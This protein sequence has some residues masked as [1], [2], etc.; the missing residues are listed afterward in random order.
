MPPHA[1]GS[2]DIITS[3]HAM[4]REIGFFIVPEFEILD[5][6]GPLSAF[7]MVEMTDGTRPYRLRVVSEA[8]GAVVSTAWLEITTEKL[9]ALRFDTLIVV[10]GRGARLD[11]QPET[12]LDA[13]RSAT[14]RTRRIASVCTGAF[15]L[16]AAGL[17]DQRQATTHWRHA[18][19]LQR[20]YPGVRVDGDRIFIRDGA[21]WTSAGIT[22]GIDLALAMIEADHG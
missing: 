12:R 20:R 1:S 9:A 22:A 3:F 10:G 13:I 4:P 19:A 14:T 2:N 16:A 7:R 8:G 5:L 15:I 18:A 17:L 6:T 21:I 11:P